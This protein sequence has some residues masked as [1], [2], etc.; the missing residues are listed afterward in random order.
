[1]I[2]F[3]ETIEPTKAFS[4]IA[5]KHKEFDENINKQSVN[6]LILAKLLLSDRIIPLHQTIS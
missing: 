1:M 4:R 3:Y 5:A 6:Q 2:D